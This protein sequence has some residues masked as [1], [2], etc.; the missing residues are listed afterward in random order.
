MKFILSLSFLIDF[1]WNGSN[2]LHFMEN[3][4]IFVIHFGDHWTMAKWRC[5]W[6][7]HV[8]R[9]SIFSLC[10]L[11]TSNKKP[12]EVFALFS[13]H[14]L[15]LL[16]RLASKVVNEEMDLQSRFP[17]ISSSRDVFISFDRNTLSRTTNIC[18]HYVFVVCVCRSR[19]H[20]G[21]VCVCD[22]ILNWLFLV[23][24]INNQTNVVH[25]SS[26]IAC[27]QH[28]QTPTGETECEIPK[29]RL[30]NCDVKQWVT[31]HIYSSVWTFEHSNSH[32]FTVAH[33]TTA[34]AMYHENNIITSAIVVLKHKNR[35]GANGNNRKWI[36]EKR[37]RSEE[38]GQKPL[39]QHQRIPIR[40]SPFTLQRIFFPF[41]SRLFRPISPN[42]WYKNE[43]D[44]WQPMGMMEA[45][46]TMA[47]RW[48]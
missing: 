30:T 40:L 41:F 16:L 26:S 28:N 35:F 5:T 21:C 38:H 15:R 31:S 25:A 39:S 18:R 3:C 4:A 11:C 48:P 13:I 33:V 34:T 20:G 27:F 1:I 19:V 37:G 10:G 12:Q 7:E 2:D 47:A 17:L 32:Q 43:R 9:I 46:Q 23:G 44:K 29:E 8:Q 42:R 24:K 45:I 36:G 22:A 14:F 6:D